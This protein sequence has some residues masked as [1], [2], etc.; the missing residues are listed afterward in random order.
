MLIYHIF[1]CGL[2]HRLPGKT[3]T[4]AK[5]TNQHP[6]SLNE[7]LPEFLVQSL[8]NFPAVGNRSFAAAL[9]RC[10]TEEEDLHGPGLLLGILVVE[11]DALSGGIICGSVDIA[12]DL[13]ARR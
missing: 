1:V 6:L 5:I 9:R 4:V 3:E 8:I 12:T 2:K 7:S 11:E 13:P 10:L